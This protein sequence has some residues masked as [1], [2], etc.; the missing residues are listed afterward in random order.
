MTKTEAVRNV[1]DHHWP[2][3][4]QLVDFAEQGAGFGGD[5]GYYGLLYPDDLDEYD[6]EV[7]GEF[8]PE[9]YIE[10][11]YWNGPQDII[12]VEE[13][14]Y[15]EELLNYLKEKGNSI[16][17]SRVELLI[18]NLASGREKTRRF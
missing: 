6:K 11:Y 18:T 1:F 10:V 7:N 5:D 14:F 16:L 4:E 8:I 9:G 12:H 2:S 3:D 13:S 15:L 17:T